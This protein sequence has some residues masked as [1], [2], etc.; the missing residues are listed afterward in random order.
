MLFSIITIC[1]NCEKEL[2]KTLDSMLSQDYTGEVEYIVKDGASSDGTA[3][4]AESYREAFEQKGYTFRVISEA[5]KGIYDAMNAGIRAAA[6]ELVGMINAGDRY[7]KNALST[8]AETYAKEPFDMFYADINLVK[9]NGSIMVKHSKL[10]KYPSSRNWNHPTTFIRNAVY[11][12]CG[13]Y[14]NDGPHDDYDLVLRIRKAGK[15]VVVKNEV[16]ADFAVGGVSNQRSLKKSVE[17]IKSRYS[18]YR[19]NGYSRLYIIECLM[20]EVAKFILC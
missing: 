15:K 6:G 18:C 3:A 20:M 12:E 7:E 4:L 14:R 13:L 5:D 10:D 8:V 11:K 19:N 16:L 2:K 9:E 1:Y 17:R